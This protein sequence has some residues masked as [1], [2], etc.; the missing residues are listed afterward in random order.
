MAEES[1]SIALLA[2][3]LDN[4]HSLGRRLRSA[5]PVNGLRTER[6]QTTIAKTQHGK[7]PVSRVDGLAARGLSAFTMSLRKA[8]P[9]SQTR[10]R[11]SGPCSLMIGKSL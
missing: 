1:R 10:Y 5:S 2:L 3:I 6:K 9:A 11:G 4:I 7:L 8:S